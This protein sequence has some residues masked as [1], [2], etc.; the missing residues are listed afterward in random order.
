MMAARHPSGKPSGHSLS[1]TLS[2]FLIFSFY[3]LLHNY[4]PGNVLPVFPSVYFPSVSLGNPPFSAFLWHRYEQEDKCQRIQ[5]RTCKNQMFKTTV[6]LAHFNTIGP[7]P[8]NTCSHRHKLLNLT[9][10]STPPITLE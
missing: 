7:T 10:G 2:F 4:F 8:T 1:T 6:S 9:T 3:P 5:K